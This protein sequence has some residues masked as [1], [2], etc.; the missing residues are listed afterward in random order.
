MRKY[1]KMSVFLPSMLALKLA[2]YRFCIY[3]IYMV[4][5][6]DMDFNPSKCQVIIQDCTWYTIYTPWS[7]PGGCKQCQVLASNL[8]WNMHVNWVAAS[9]NKSLR[10]IRRNVKTKSPKIPEM[11]CKTFV[12]R[13]L[14]YASE[15]WDPHTKEQAHKI[16]MVQRR[17][18]W[19]TMNNW[20]STTSVTSLLHQLDW[21]TLEER[22]SVVRL[23]FFY[24]IVTGTVTIP[25]TDFTHSSSR[26]FR[27]NSITY[28]QIHIGK[29]S[30]NFSFFPLAI[31]QWNAFPEYIVVSPGLDSFKTAVGELQHH[32]P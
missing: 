17:A 6:W 9:A 31:V 22:Q 18:A 5:K 13:Q 2:V 14:K 23:F 24:K 21:Q 1:F 28:R 16:Q 19:W 12:H 11:A 20:N 8:N 4:L 10:F 25:L 26:P 29:D 27:Y 32:K 30:Y 7:G 3:G 15:V